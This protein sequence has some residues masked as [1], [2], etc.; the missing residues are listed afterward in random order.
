M[1]IDDKDI[2]KMKELYMNQSEEI[3]INECGL[4]IN[5]AKIKM[6]VDSRNQHNPPQPQ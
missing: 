1:G 6:R 3:I 2:S 4:S 5:I